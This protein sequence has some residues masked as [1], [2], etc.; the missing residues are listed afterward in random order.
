MSTL[1]V[2][3]LQVGQDSTPTN[4]LT[5]F[6]PG[7]PDGTIRL[8]SGNAGSATSKFTFDKD[9]NLT[10]AGTITATSIEGTLDDWII[11]QGD[12]DTKYGFPTNDTFTIETAGSERLRVTSAG[13]VGINEDVP[14]G[15][16]HVAGTGNYSDVYLSNS[17]S[18]HTG[19]D[20]ANIFL[21]NNLELGIWNKENGHI[22]FATNGN[23]RLRINSDGNI[24]NDNKNASDYGNTKLLISGTSAENTLTVMNKN[25]AAQDYASIAFRVAGGSTGDYTKAG[26]FAIRNTNYNQIDLAFG[27]NTTAD[28]SRVTTSHEKLR[29][30]HLGDVFINRNSGLSNA[31]V[32][33]QCDAGE[34]CVAVQ[35]SG[36]AGETNLL[37]VYN[38][39]GPNTSTIT[40]VN[41]TATPAL[42]FKIY[43]GSSSTNEKVRID[44]DGLIVKGNSKLAAINITS[45]KESPYDE[46]G[47]GET[48]FVYDTRNDADG[49][50]WRKK[51]RHTSWYNETSGTYRGTRKEFPAVAII[52]LGQVRTTIYD[53]DDPSC[54]LWMQFRSSAQGYMLGCNDD[55]PSCVTALNG[56]IYI[57]AKNV[58]G[59]FHIIDFIKDTAKRVRASVTSN[60]TH[61]WWPTGIA[62][63]NG[64]DDN[65]GLWIDTG[66]GYDSTDFGGLKSDDVWSVAVKV[67]KGAPIDPITNLPIPTIAVAVDGGISIIKPE[68]H[69]GLN[70]SNTPSYYHNDVSGHI[71]DINSNN[72]GYTLGRSV[73]WTDNDDLIFVM[74]DGNGDFDYIHTMDGHIKW[75]NTITIDTKT[76]NNNHHVRSMWRGRFSASTVYSN[77]LSTGSDWS[78]TWNTHQHKVNQ[79]TAKKGYEFAARTRGGLNHIYENPEGDNSMIAYTTKS[80]TTG[81]MVGKEKMCVMA[82]TDTTNLSGTDLAPNNCAT[83]GPGRTEANATTGWTNGGMATFASSNTRAFEGSYSLHLT[84]NTNG[85]YCY[86]TFPTTV[87]KKYTVSARLWVTHDSFTIKC[88]T[89]AGSGNEYFESPAIGTV[90]QWQ[91]F[92]GS[93]QATATTSYFNVTESST[94]Q[95]SDGYIDNVIVT[96]ADPDH[97]NTHGYSGAGALQQGVNRGL[98]V[99]GT[100]TKQPVATGAELC[101]YSGWSSSNYLY[102]AYN[103]NLNHGSGDFAFYWWMN[104]N[105]SQAGRTIW[106]ISDDDTLSSGNDKSYLRVYFNGDDLRF[107]M[108]T[109][110][111]AYD[112]VQKGLRM[113]P[114]DMKSWMLCHIIRRSN[115][116]E[117]WVN[118]RRELVRIMNT[119]MWGNSPFTAYSELRIGHDSSTGAADSEIE[120]ALF[121]SSRSAPNEHQ[122]KKMY[123]DELGLFQENAK[124]TLVGTTNDHIEAM[125]YDKR[126]DILYVGGKGGRADFSGLVRINNNTT[127]VT[128]G[129]SASNDLVVEY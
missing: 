87:G 119:G 29:I 65:G 7:S 57:G 108:S 58:Y 22:R 67:L 47:T 85:D 30:S 63:R 36:S 72:S 59:G 122:I 2:N 3:N 79:V 40:Q 26:I 25:S 17:T 102:Q 39:S 28:N 90:A 27:F 32:S 89:A 115:T 113:H 117:L 41:T 124:C 71:V 109:N 95:D 23:E 18:G 55:R 4:N 16:I 19:S 126:S 106:S 11:H 82:S 100:I 64:T 128:R 9:G 24:S 88:G 120:M 51:C 86:F 43:D 56:V 97:T 53:G 83:T 80:H 121:R 127:E 49:G 70:R 73:E 37:Q 13:K 125:A 77:L 98:Q 42:L 60:G 99:Y 123:K 118:G 46:A 129:M 31:K 101:S 104:P 81:W 10:C 21:N 75:D 62:G 74:G 48:I 112:P 38:S 92:T 34:A 6:Q 105:D 110:G 96:E 8:G 5:W 78:T 50:A 76:A 91:M 93:F 116:M 66:R 12:A 45:G 103:P 33:I 54:P 52:V 94:S 111:F 44:D 15:T 84:A 69:L 68:W 107:D 1:K 35:A 114:Q 61:G 14:Q 20:G